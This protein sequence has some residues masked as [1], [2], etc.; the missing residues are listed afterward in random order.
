MFVLRKKIIRKGCVGKLVCEENNDDKENDMVE[1]VKREYGNI[2]CKENT[3]KSVQGNSGKCDLCL[4]FGSVCYYLEVKKYD[5]CNRANYPKQMVAECLWNRKYHDA[6]GKYGILVDFDKK[7][8][9]SELLE[10]VKEHVRKEDW[11]KFGEDFEC[12]RIFLFDGIDN[13]LYYILWNGL[14]EE[15]MLSHKVKLEK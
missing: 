11:I 9:K 8:N 13:D 14:F 7:S 12:E 6:K 4:K 10:I 3:S 5:S 1:K 15:N 2:I